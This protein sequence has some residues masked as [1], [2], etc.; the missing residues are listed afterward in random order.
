MKRLIKQILDSVNLGLSAH[1]M[2]NRCKYFTDIHMQ[3]R[4][5]RFMNQGGPDGLPVP[6]P[7]LIYLVSGN[8]DIRLFCYKGLLGSECIKSVLAKNRLDINTFESILDFGCGC[9]RIMRHWKTLS[10]PSFHGTDYN[11][12][13]VNWCQENLTFAEFKTNGLS[14]NLGYEDEKF[15]FIYAISVFTHLPEGL[16]HFWIS[17]LTRILRPSGFLLIT[18][19]GTTHLHQLTLKERQDFES[20][21]LVVTRGEYSG[22]NVCGAFHP[23]QY[24]RQSLAKNL[25][26][27]DF[28]PGGAKDAGYQNIF[29]LQKPKKRDKGI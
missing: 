2:Y 16:Q 22:T 27:A 17:E 9:G 21:Q 7:Q 13:L 4:N 8:Y 23:E 18:V 20:G 26:V 15:D 29:L 5:A 19:K 6:P 1:D 24:V 12:V 11:P 14:S 3:F 25:T 28:V 10:A